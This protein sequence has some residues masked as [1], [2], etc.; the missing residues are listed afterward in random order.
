MYEVYFELNYETVNYFLLQY[1]AK[2]DLQEANGYECFSEYSDDIPNEILVSKCLAN[3]SFQLVILYGSDP[4]P[5]IQ[6]YLHVDDNVFN[7]FINGCITRSVGLTVSSP[8]Y[9]RGGYLRPS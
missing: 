1:D 9:T 7:G 2:T 8:N 5:H 6:F 4:E 3:S